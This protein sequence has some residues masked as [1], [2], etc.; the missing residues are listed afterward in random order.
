[1]HF[2]SY[3]SQHCGILCYSLKSA[4]KYHFLSNRS[5]FHHCK[6]AI[7]ALQENFGKLQ[8]CC[9]EIVF[10]ST[11]SCQQQQLVHAHLYSIHHPNLCGYLFL[12]FTSYNKPGHVLIRVKTEC[13][14]LETLFEVNNNA[15][16]FGEKGSILAAARDAGRKFLYITSQIH[17]MRH[18]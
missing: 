4:G 14:A 1:M 16:G 18:K 2:R 10:I 17:H 6:F 8:S 13:N 5:N 12:K 15:N 3:Q 7:I 9:I 11:I